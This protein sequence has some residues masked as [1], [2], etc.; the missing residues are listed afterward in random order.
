MLAV[1]A[2]WEVTA[3]IAVRTEKHL[4]QAL[5]LLVSADIRNAVE[6]LIELYVRRARGQGLRKKGF[7]DSPHR[8][9]NRQFL[10]GGSC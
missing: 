10:R 7:P 8:V 6:K 2:F 3:N 4:R 9:Q 5:S 1:A